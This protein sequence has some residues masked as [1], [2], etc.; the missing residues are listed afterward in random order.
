MEI[1]IKIENRLPDFNG[2]VVVKYYD[3]NNEVKEQIAWFETGDRK[4]ARGFSMM[5]PYKIN[6]I[7]AW[8]QIEA[9]LYG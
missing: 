4:F 1:W 8:K 7:F 5:P 3:E 6:R 9:T 2:K